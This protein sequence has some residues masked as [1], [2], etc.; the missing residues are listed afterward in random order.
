MWF[1]LLLHTAMA[2]IKGLE[3]NKKEAVWHNFLK[4]ECGGHVVSSP[5][6]VPLRMVVIRVLSLPG[7]VQAGVFLTFSKVA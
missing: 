3:K 1:Q 4:E 6:K 5:V 2:K 7:R